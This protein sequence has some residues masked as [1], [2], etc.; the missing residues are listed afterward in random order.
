MIANSK[1]MRNYLS[2]DKFLSYLVGNWSFG[3]SF[4]K[5]LKFILIYILCGG[6]TAGVIGFGIPSAIANFYGKYLL[7]T[8]GFCLFGMCITWII[9]LLLIKI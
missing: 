5:V 3:G 4:V 1:R 2:Q 7:Q 6:L 9:P 8:I